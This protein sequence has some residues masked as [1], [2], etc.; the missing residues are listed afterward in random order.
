MCLPQKVVTHSCGRLCYHGS[1]SCPSERIY[2]P[3]RRRLMHGP[4]WRSSASRHVSQT[5]AGRKRAQ[6]A[7]HLTTRTPWQHGKA[8]KTAP[9]HHRRTASGA[10]R[11][12]WPEASEISAGWPRLGRGAGRSPRA[13]R[14]MPRRIEL[15]TGRPRAT[16][17]G[18]SRPPARH[19]DVATS[20]SSRATELVARW[21][22]SLVLRWSSTCE[23]FNPQRS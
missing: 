9:L 15:P 22:R 4:G 17:S 23:T 7:Q 13:R 11:P 6:H 21:A 14:R 12:E 1:D 2:K 8:S 3:I 20:R 5:A 10:R 18:R 16:W 19:A